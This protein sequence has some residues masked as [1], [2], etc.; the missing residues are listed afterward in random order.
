[1]RYTSS[2]E[3]SINYV[4]ELLEANGVSYFPKDWKLVKGGESFA[5]LELWVDEYALQQSSG[6]L[7]N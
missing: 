1:M 6:T 2:I 5:Q 3:E 7:T 4:A